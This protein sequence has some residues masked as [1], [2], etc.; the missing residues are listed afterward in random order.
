MPVEGHRRL[1]ILTEANTVVGSL[2]STS[3]FPPQYPIGIRAVC[4]VLH[5]PACEERLSLGWRLF[6]RHGVFYFSRINTSEEYI[7][8]VHNCLVFWC[9][10]GYK[11]SEYFLIYTYQ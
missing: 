11:Q 4:R 3:A 1:A 8:P 9:W 10:L 6:A 2:Y 5:A 7:C